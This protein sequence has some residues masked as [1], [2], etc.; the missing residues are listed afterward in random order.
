MKSRPALLRN[1]LIGIAALAGAVQAQTYR[2]AVLADAPLAYYPLGDPLPVDRALNQGLLGTQLDGVHT[3]VRHRAGGALASSGN[4]ATFYDGSAHTLIP[5]QAALNPPANQPFTIEAWLRPTVEENIA[6]GQAPLSNRKTDGNREG[7]VFFQR[8][9]VDVP[10]RQQG[11]N[12]RMYS[13]VGSAVSI[14]ITGGTYITGVWSHVVL[15]W[16]GSTATLY[17]DGTPV[18]TSPPGTYLPNASTSFGI[19]AY[20]DPAG[21]NPFTGDID[22]VAFYPVALTE[23]QV[24]DHY[25]HRF[26]TVTGSSYQEMVVEDGAVLLQRMD[27]YDAGRAV[28]YNAGTLGAQGNGIHF[29]GVTHSV[30]GALAAGGDTAT[31]YD[32]VDKTSNDVTY[33]TGLPYDP[34][35]N[36][37]SFSWEGWVRPTEEGKGNAQ[38][39]FM[40]Y[41]ASGNRVGWV[42]WQRGSRAATSGDRGWNFRLYNANG[43]NML[44]NIITGSGAGGYDVGQWQHLAITYHQPTL[45][46]VFYVNGVEVATQTGSGAP[47]VPNSGQVVPAIGG[48]ANGR[49]NP[50]Y[51]DIDEVALY[52]KVLSSSLVAARY[53]AGTSGSPATPY[54]E[55][56]LSDGPVGYYRL[57]EQIQAPAGNLGTLGTAALGTYV[58]SPAPIPGPAAPVFKGFDSGSGGSAFRGA[59]SYV[60]LNNPPGLN[61]AGP[62]TLEAWVQPAAAQANFANNIIAH[63]ANDTFASEVFLRIENG[64]YEVGSVGG[65]ASAPVPASD[66]GTG[67]WV[68]LAGTWSAGTWTLYRNGNVLAT[69]ADANGATAVANANWAIGARG[70]WKEGQPF[71]FPTLPS[72]ANHR[73]FT[74]GISDAAIYNKALTADQ[75]ENHF[76]AGVGPMPLVITRP[77]GTITLEWSAGILQQ[78]DNLGGF[79]DVEGAVSPYTPADGPRHFYRLRF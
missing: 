61:I 40:N 51:G 42:L 73:A 37:E 72:P 3:R 18:A 14:D 27:G 30:P 53:A 57:N 4:P 43:S 20:S 45:T 71:T 10:G 2:S 78:S 56:V 36:T 54:E 35:L 8:A 21:S 38:C 41:T 5:N 1:C 32:G 29:P 79:E 52:D 12:F 11:W 64:N 67:A 70:R 47:Y 15:V 34:R 69:G 46:A 44:I 62:I 55:L 39:V 48:F 58:N 77:D 25:D 75:I 7:W 13:G 24:L 16:N 33:A 17:V 9:S 50:F 22:E 74:G 63:G 6:V 60:E 28:A 49:E 19:G 23:S 31:R 68:H 76:L 59:A 65:K 26:Q 66:L